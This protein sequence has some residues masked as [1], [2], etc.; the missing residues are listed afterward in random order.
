MAHAQTSVDI[1]VA[2]ARVIAT[3]ALMAGDLE[4][5][6]QIAR[7]LLARDP[8]DRVALVVLAAAAPRLDDP[9]EGR[10]A[11]VRAWRLSETDAQKY[12]AARLTALA[13]AAEE[14]FTLATFW[15]RRALTV[16]P[17]DAEQERTL[18]DARAVTRRNPWSTNLIFSLVPSN[19]VNGGAS[20]DETG[21]LSLS[22]DAQA[23]AGVRATLGFSTAYRL[24]ETRTDRSSVSLRYQL[25]RVALEDAGEPRAEG[26]DD[27]IRNEDFATDYFAL[28]FDHMHA[29]ENGTLG[30]N[31]SFGSFAYG[32]EPHYDF[33]RIGLSRALSLSDATTLQLSVQREIQDYESTGIRETRRTTLGTALAYRRENGDRITGSLSRL[34]SDSFSNNHTFEEWTLQGSYSWSQPIGPISLSINAGLKYADYPEY[35]FFGDIGREDKTFLYGANIGLPDV[36]YAGF[37]P[38]LQLSGNIAESTVNRFTRDGFSMGFVLNSTF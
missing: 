30:V 34:R 26:S 28:S 20:E 2:D 12:E 37:S 35:F 16:T 7:V 9:A 18:Q 23:L 10:R 17:N 32:L 1:P 38:M 25:S 8:D 11:G 15:L 36:S 6:L 21:S 4:L 14:R 22:R 3:R 27:K 19:N 5:A 24:H 13:A 29:F 31:L 33:K